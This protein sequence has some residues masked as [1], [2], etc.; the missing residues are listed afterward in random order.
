MINFVKA[1][2]L[3]L[4]ALILSTAQAQDIIVSNDQQAPFSAYGNSGVGQSF[5]SP[6]DGKMTAVSVRKFFGGSTATLY[7]FANADASG[8]PIY[9]QSGI[10]LIPTSYNSPQQVVNLTSAVPI[11]AGQ[12]YS[13]VFVSPGGMTLYSN[14]A[15]DYSGGT[16]LYFDG[17]NYGFSA[18]R[19]IDFAIAIVSTIF[20]IICFAGAIEGYL[21]ARLNYVLRAIYLLLALGILNH[22]EIIRLSALAGAIALTVFHVLQQRKDS[23]LS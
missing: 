13:F 9:S 5:T 15:D 3:L 16:L 23:S 21:L 18:A 22:N 19:D 7:V 14:N 17:A 6:I 1:L 20:I 11:S 8:S 4:S 2:G 12:A 10:N